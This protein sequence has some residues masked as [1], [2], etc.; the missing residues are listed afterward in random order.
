MP[1]LITPTAAQT[2]SITT[3]SGQIVWNAWNNSSTTASIT[4]ATTDSVWDAWIIHDGTSTSTTSATTITATASSSADAVF[5]Q[6]VQEGTTTSATNVPDRV[7]IQ[8]AGDDSHRGRLHRPRVEVVRSAP[9]RLTE[10][11]RAEQQRRAEERRR[12]DE[13]R[14]REREAA[15]ARAMALLQ[16]ILTDEQNRDLESHGYFFTRG[17]SGRLYRIGK[18]RTGNIKVV[19]PETLEWTESLCIHQQEY[20][21]VADTMLMQKLMIETRE[22]HLRA[23]ANISYRDGGYDRARRGLLTGDKL[24]EVLPFPEREAA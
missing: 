6:W 15:D 22:A 16:S 17:Q 12:L 2:A 23:Y 20:V 21:P 8:W 9:P 19:N 4:S 13:E 7:F 1:T 24:A 14:R 11:Q 5:V 3:G 10:E 18:G